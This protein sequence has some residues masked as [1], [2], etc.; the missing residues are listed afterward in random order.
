VALNASNRNLQLLSVG[1]QAPMDQ[2]EME[3]LIRNVD[4]RTSR[5]E[6]WT[7]RIEERTTRIEQILPTLVTKEDAKAFLT[8]ED[9]Q[10]FATKDDLKAFATKDDLKA[11][12]TKDDLKPFATKDDLKQFATKDDVRDEGERTRRHFDVVAEQMKAD[13]ALIAEG[14]KATRVHIDG[15]LAETRATL[16]SH[17]KRIMKLETKSMNPGGKPKRRSTRHD[18]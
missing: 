11:Y 7:T 1:D 17:D 12:A 10:A 5:I 16:E 3:T 14:H 8:K 9:A 13:I 15:Q 2:S 18:P 4:A 6:E